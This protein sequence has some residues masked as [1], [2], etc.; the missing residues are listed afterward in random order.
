M[1]LYC[2]AGD[3][4]SALHQ[5]ERCRDA[6]KRELGME[7]DDDTKALERNIRAGH[8]LSDRLGPRSSRAADEAREALRKPG[9]SVKRR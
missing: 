4:A 6:L 2:L 1:L 8:P 3:R 7:P 5:Y 9:L